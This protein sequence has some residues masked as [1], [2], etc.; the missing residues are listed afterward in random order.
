M[1]ATELGNAVLPGCARGVCG[2]HPSK[3][4]HPVLHGSHRCRNQTH[5]SRKLYCKCAEKRAGGINSGTRSG[6][7]CLRLAQAVLLCLDPVREHHVLSLEYPLLTLPGTLLPAFDPL[8]SAVFRPFLCDLRV[9]VIKRLGGCAPGLSAISSLA[10]GQIKRKQPRSP[11]ILPA[12]GTD[13]AY[14]LRLG[15]D[16]RA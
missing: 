7:G 8:T 15:P 1:S 2:A 10:H 3:R 12:A 4:R 16:V 13:F 14:V 9:R 5:F 11:Y 6:Y